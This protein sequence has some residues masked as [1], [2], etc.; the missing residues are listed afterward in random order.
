MGNKPGLSETICAAICASGAAACGTVSRAVLEPVMTDAQRA[1]L[2]LRVPEWRTVFCA[3][4]PYFANVPAP[5]HAISRYAWG[6]DYHKVLAQRLTPAAEHL[7]ALGAHAEVLVDASPVP[8]RAAALYAGIGILGDHG[9][10]IV[11]PY[12]SYV[13]LGTIVTDSEDP[14]APLAQTPA[15]SQCTHCGACRAACPSGALSPEEFHPERCLSHLSQKKGD[16]SP[17]EQALLQQNDCLWGCD[18]CQEACP[19]NR[20]PRETALPEFREALIQTLSQDQLNGLSN[21]EFQR[22]YGT[23]AFAWRGP[24]VL[25]RNLELLAK[26]ESETQRAFRHE[27]GNDL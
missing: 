4:F 7:R 24:A 9:L 8:E 5:R 12:G 26:S 3:A 11:P 15:I 20:D 6:L 19:Y 21:R 2:A 18:V 25:R 16:L 27:K 17:W 22:R 10:V 23:R 1:Q 13:F 14:D